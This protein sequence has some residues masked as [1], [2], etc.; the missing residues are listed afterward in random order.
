MKGNENITLTSKIHTDLLQW[1][2]NSSW[3]HSFK[4]SVCRKFG[5]YFPQ[6]GDFGRYA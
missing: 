2:L 6:A 3:A 5:V 4:I 1:C